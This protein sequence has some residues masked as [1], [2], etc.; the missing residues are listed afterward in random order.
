MQRHDCPVNDPR[1]ELTFE[2][3]GGCL[4]RPSNAYTAV[5]AERMNIR[6]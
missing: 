6:R 4:F 5:C 3:A 1:I 2:T